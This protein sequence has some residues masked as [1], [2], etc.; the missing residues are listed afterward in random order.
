MEKNSKILIGVLAIMIIVAGVQAF[1]FS[2]LANSLQDLKVSG[3]SASSTT[4]SPTP[5]SSPSSGGS[6]SNVLANL[7]TQVGGC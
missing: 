3:V 4:S 1:Q 7:P 5:A 2:A 6:V